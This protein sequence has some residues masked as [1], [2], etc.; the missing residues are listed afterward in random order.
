MNFV[1]INDTQKKHLNNHKLV[2]LLTNLSK[3][4]L[5]AFQKYLHSPFFN[6]RTDVIELYELLL[7]GIRSGNGVPEKEAIFQCIYS[8]TPFSDQNFR[9]LFSYL[10]KLCEQF[11][12][13]QEILENPLLMQTKSAVR[14]RKKKTPILFQKC[15]NQISDKL[16]KQP[17]RNSFY[18]EHL[19][20]IKIEQYRFDSEQR[21]SDQLNLQELSDT[22]DIAYLVNKLQHVCTLLSHQS[23]YTIKYNI[24]LLEPVLSYIEN[25]NLLQI[26]AINVYYHCYWMLREADVESRFWTFKKLLFEYDHYFSDSE[27]KDLYTLATNIC[28][29]RMNA[30][31][32]GYFQEALDIYKE[33]IRKEY[34]LQD[35]TLSR[36]TYHNIVGVGLQTKDYEWVDFFIHNYKNSVEKK[37][38]ESAF[39]F[40][41]A[42]LEYMRK[43]YDTVQ[44][45]LQKSNYRD[46]LINLSAK[47]ILLKIYYEQHEFDLL[48]SHLDAMKNYIRRKSV[49]GYHRT[50]YTNIVKFARQ[51][52][53]LNPYDANARKQLEASIRS[54]QVLTEREWFLATVNAL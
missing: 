53:L 41:L 50:N 24:G 29:R 10:Y 21:P 42:R 52:M 18:F 39:S 23:V 36:R 11:L 27:V 9:L 31:Y 6:Q 28:I 33:G 15:I 54:E 43:N 4:D 32:E 44:D 37:F 48:H 20:N 3:K 38:R 19:R 49:L 35:G 51:L 13:I 14:L 2:L 7:K 17:L 47:T 45:L 22:I 46:I 34:L 8:D 25:K 26:P 5:N 1:E 12:G 30:G 16:E 40:N